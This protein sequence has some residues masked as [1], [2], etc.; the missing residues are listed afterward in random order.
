MFWPAEFEGNRKMTM[1]NIYRVKFDQGALKTWLSELKTD[2]ANALLPAVD[3]GLFEQFVTTEKNTRRQAGR[4]GS[5]AHCSACLPDQRS[6]GPA[7]LREF[8]RRVLLRYRYIAQRF[9]A[10]GQPSVADRLCL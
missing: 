4:S 9:G 10:Y 7:R 5:G 2:A 1:S 3:D 6:S 8:A